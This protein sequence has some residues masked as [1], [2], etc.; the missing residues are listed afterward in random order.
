MAVPFVTGRVFYTMPNAPH[1]SRRLPALALAAR[2]CWGARVVIDLQY[3]PAYDTIGTLVLFHKSSS[4]EPKY[5]L[6]RTSPPEST[7]ESVA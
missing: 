5:A 4:L 6:V 1:R 7:A 3:L 2:R